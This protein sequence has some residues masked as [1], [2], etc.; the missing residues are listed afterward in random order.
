MNVGRVNL[1][2]DFKQNTALFLQSVNVVQT[3]QC[4]TVG[5]SRSLSVTRVLNAQIYISAFL[6]FRMPIIIISF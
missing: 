4:S 5:P 3:L 2:V 6:N 1:F